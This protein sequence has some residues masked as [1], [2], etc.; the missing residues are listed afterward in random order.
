M[1][2]TAATAATLGLGDLILPSMVAA[3]AEEGWGTLDAMHLALPLPLI[4][5]PTVG[6]AGA[7]VWWGFS[8]ITGGSVTSN[9][10]KSGG[11]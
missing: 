9:S 3:Y 4:L 11:C 10:R 1:V 8:A 6:I 5:A 7:C 2:T